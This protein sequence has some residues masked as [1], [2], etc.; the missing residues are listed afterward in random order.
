MVVVSISYTSSRLGFTRREPESEERVATARPLGRGLPSAL[1]CGS[2]KAP[3]LM[4]SAARAA[5]RRNSAS[6]V[7]GLLVTSS[8]TSSSRNIPR[9]RSDGSLATAAAWALLAWRQAFLTTVKMFSLVRCV[10]SMRGWSSFL[11]ATCVESNQ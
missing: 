6:G 5:K 4:R 10:S 2:A 7:G 9:V 11:S 1:K 8:T 3:L